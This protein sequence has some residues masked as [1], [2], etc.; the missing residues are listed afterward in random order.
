[1]SAFV[2]S[3][4]HIDFLVTAALTV[5]GR[6]GFQWWRVDESG[7]YAGWRKLDPNAEQRADDDY[8]AFYTPSQAGQILLSENVASVSHR[9]SYSGRVQYYGAEEAAK[10][11]DDTIETLP[12][13]TDRFYMAPYVF[14]PFGRFD[15]SPG[16]VFA[17]VDC[18]DYQ[19]CEHDG[20]RSSEAYSFLR[21]LRDAW[22]RRC[23]GYEGTWEVAS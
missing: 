5:G 23:A 12:G 4:Q 21:S 20:W 18:L 2:V 13:P 8:M 22:C 6:D 1:M 10:M 14:A 16:K 9:Y 11:D 7:D 17:A 19:S 15:G 3:K